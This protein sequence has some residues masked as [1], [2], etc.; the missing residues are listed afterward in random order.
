MSVGEVVDSIEVAAT[1]AVVRDVILDMPAYPDW[2]EHAREVTVLS[3]DDQGRPH[4]VR[5]RIYAKIAEVTYTLAYR[6]EGDDIH[7]S[8]V[9]GQMISRLDG[10]Y[11]V[12]AVGDGTRVGARLDLDISLPLPASMKQDIARTVVEHGLAALKER[13]EQVA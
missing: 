7:W 12:S 11:L 1:P 3:H 5:F 2:L 10:S 6:Y 13:A 9:D 8:L 4:E